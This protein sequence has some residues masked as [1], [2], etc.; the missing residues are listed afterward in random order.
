[1]NAQRQPPAASPPNAYWASQ[2][3]STG[4]TKPPDSS[5]TDHTVRPRDRERPVCV[6]AVTIARVVGS[7]AAAPIPLTASPIHITSAR[8]PDAVP[9]PGVRMQISRPTA[10]SSAP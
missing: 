7:T 3:P 9:A 1:M 8:V 10:I 6:P 4:A 2:P 5:A